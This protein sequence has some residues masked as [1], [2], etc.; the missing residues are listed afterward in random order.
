MMGT[1]KFK[2]V[3]R[4]V[5]VCPWCGHEDL[6]WDEYDP[7]RSKFDTECPECGKTYTLT[8]QRFDTLFTTVKK[9][10]DTPPNE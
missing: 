2:T 3:N 7:G 10:E 8:I 4:L 9:V 6:D 5:P 1:E